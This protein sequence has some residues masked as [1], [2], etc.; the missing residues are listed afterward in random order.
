MGMEETITTTDQPLIPLEDA[1]MT[2]PITIVGCGPGARSYLTLEAIDAVAQADVIVGAPRV[3][4]LFPDSSAERIVFKSDLNALVDLIANRQK[5]G[6]VAVLVT[7]D[8]SIHSLAGPIVERFGI[9]HCRVIP[10]I[11]SVQL[12][13]A[14]LGLDMAKTLILSTHHRLPDVDEAA[15]AAFET[16]AIL[17]G[18]ESSFVCIQSLV[19]A[20]THTCRVL[21]LSNLSLDDER[22]EEVAIDAITDQDPTQ[23]GIVVVTQRRNKT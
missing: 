13:L 1:R 16:I 20:L 3:L 12:A 19:G 5:S 21:V 2:R 10:G 9:E 15:L 8:P 23:P 6:S 17:T 4:A 22:I 7:G 11:S 14:R 18:H